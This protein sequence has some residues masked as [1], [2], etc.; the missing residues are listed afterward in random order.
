M[1]PIFPNGLAL[2]KYLMLCCLWL[3][4]HQC[5]ND[6]VE[7]TEYHCFAAIWLYRECGHCAFA[8]C[9]LKCIAPCY[10]L[11]VHPF[12]CH[13]H[14]CSLSHHIEACIS[15]EL[16]HTDNLDVLKVL[17]FVICQSWCC[18]WKWTGTLFHKTRELWHCWV[19]SSGVPSLLQFPPHKVLIKHTLALASATT[20][21]WI[22]LYCRQQQK[23][24]QERQLWLHL[25]S[26]L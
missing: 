26:A 12:V 21:S 17:K 25:W 23:V 6:F 5:L 18:F 14:Q 16:L 13:H 4:F 7:G 22:L 19:G 10:I 8:A 20:S 15:I 11:H 2:S 3:A 9:T 1:L 24:R